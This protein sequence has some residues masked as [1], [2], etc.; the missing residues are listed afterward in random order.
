MPLLNQ[1]LIICLLGLTTAA[2]GDLECTA[3][4]LA[5]EDREEVMFAYESTHFAETSHTD[6]DGTSH[7]ILDYQYSTNFQLMCEQ[8]GGVYH[9][10]YFNA[11]C[12]TESGDV[13]ET[14][15]YLSATNFP[16]C[17]DSICSPD[18]AQALFEEFTLRPT[19]AV[20][21][22]HGKSYTTCTGEVFNDVNDDPDAVDSSFGDGAPEVDE[23]DPPIEDSSI[24]TKQKTQLDKTAAIAKA[25]EALQPVLE[26][27]SVASPEIAMMVIIDYNTDSTNDFRAACEDNGFRY[28][29]TDSFAM[30]CT[31]G[32]KEVRSRVP[33]F[34]MCLGRDCGDDDAYDFEELMEHAFVHGFEEKGKDFTCTKIN[35]ENILGT[36][37]EQSAALFE[38]KEMID[39][40][41]AMS[42]QVNRIELAPALRADDSTTTLIDIDY[43]SSFTENFSSAC[44]ENGF[45]YIQ[46]HGFAMD[47]TSDTTKLE[48]RVKYFPKCLGQSCNITDSEYDFETMKERSFLHGGSED[49]EDFECVQVEYEED[50]VTV[51]ALVLL[52]MILSIPALLCHFC[53]VVGL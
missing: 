31:N 16:R 25:F 15:E 24:C 11:T 45:V 17:Y 48:Y 52:Y 47:C 26:Q 23:Q 51:G 13:G 10:L 7:V 9:G 36:C 20:N 14:T 6:G 33:F 3:G 1:P 2:M 34:P 22:K 19:E 44:E 12:V 42:P 32:D 29:E 37:E 46:T 43:D 28:L 4:T 49:P 40:F 35:Y 38:Q 53:I 27:E 39:T 41:K 50:G 18:E 21:T 30:K 5:L 8:N